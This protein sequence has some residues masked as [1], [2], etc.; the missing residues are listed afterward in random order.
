[1]RTTV[2]V[3]VVQIAIQFKDTSYKK[4]LY[5]LKNLNKRNGSYKC[6]KNKKIG[7]A[8]IIFRNWYLIVF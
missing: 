2:H 5:R 8:Y 1:M 7:Y 3:F 6:C 4:K